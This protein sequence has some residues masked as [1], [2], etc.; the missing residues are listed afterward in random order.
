MWARSAGPRVIAFV[1][2]AAVL[3]FSL[4]GPAAG[5]GSRYGLGR[6]PTPAEI[7]AWDIDVRPDFTGL[8][9][10]SG[11]VERGQEIWEAKCAS[12][13]GV[14]GESNDVFNPIIGGTTAADVKSGRV[15]SLT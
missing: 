6:A 13:H 10:G 5:A 15:A 4:A 12:C 2:A 11:S 7:A 9:K 3:A 1:A 8:P 14:F